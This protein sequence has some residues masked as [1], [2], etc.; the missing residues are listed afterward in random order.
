MEIF[1]KNECFKVSMEDQILLNKEKFEEMENA[2]LSQVMKTSKAM[3]ETFKFALIYTGLV[4]EKQNKETL[5]SL[6]DFREK[7]W[8]K[9]LSRREALKKYMK[10]AQ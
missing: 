7:N 5:K 6:K 2:W 10:L 3:L 8:D 9:N 4:S 1:I